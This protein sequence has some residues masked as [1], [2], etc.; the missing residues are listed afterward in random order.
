[1]PRLRPRLDL[2]QLKRMKKRISDSD[3][4]I[5]R[6][7]GQ[8]PGGQH[9]NKTAS[10]VRL[11]HIPTGTQVTIDGRNQHANLRKARKELESRVAELIAAEQA[12]ARKA[13]RDEAIKDQTTLRTYNFKQGVVH[14]H[15]TGKTASLKEVLGKGRIDLLHGDVE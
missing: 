7:T 12:D 6:I 10:C 2:Q 11:T 1:V 3:I 8:G 4:K 14:D 9:R 13:R 5:E 15:R